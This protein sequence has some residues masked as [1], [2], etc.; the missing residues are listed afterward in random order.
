MD[1]SCRRE[2]LISSEFHWK[3]G[4]LCFESVNDKQEA[5]IVWR[6]MLGRK[7]PNHVLF[8]AGLFLEL[9]VEDSKRR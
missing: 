1:P 5:D 3:S 7:F 9:Q 4:Q 8:S 2:L 6:Q